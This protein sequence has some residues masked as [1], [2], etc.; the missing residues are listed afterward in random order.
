M[1]I[2]MIVCLGLVVSFFIWNADMQIQEANKVKEKEL[3]DKGLLDLYE[4]NP[5]LFDKH[6]KVNTYSNNLDISFLP[7]GHRIE[8]LRIVEEERR[9]RE[10]GIKER[11][12]NYD[13]LL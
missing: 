1:F 12:I 2:T 5:D 6:E 4:N 8:L 9:K 7:E 13:E 11:H 10:A 3:L